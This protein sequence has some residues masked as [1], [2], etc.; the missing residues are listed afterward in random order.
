MISMSV[1]DCIVVASDSCMTMTTT[2][3]QNDVSQV[4]AMSYTE[5]TAKMVVFRR[6]LVV[7]YCDNMFVNDDLTVFQFL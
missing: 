6:R 4:T 7:T 2:K 3:Q 1:P 5:H